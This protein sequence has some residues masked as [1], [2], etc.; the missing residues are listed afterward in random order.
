MSEKD[1]K[2]IKVKRNPKI[3][4]QEADP[5]LPPSEPKPAATVLLSGLSKKQ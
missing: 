1:S 5:S 4:I 2:D 3:N